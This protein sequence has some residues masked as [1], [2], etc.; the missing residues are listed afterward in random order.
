[1][2]EARIP[3]INP[4]RG[5]GANA[6]LLGITWSVLSASQQVAVCFKNKTG[7]QAP[8]TAYLL[9]NLLFSPGGRGGANT[10]PFPGA[11]DTPL[12]AV[13]CGTS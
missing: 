4:H 3:A 13:T 10:V 12:S 5:L 2:V 9:V 7:L 6:L 11:L 1:M 8:L